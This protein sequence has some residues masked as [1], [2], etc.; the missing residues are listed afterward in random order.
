LAQLAFDPFTILAK[1]AKPAK[2]QK[3][4]GPK[5]SKGPR[6]K[7]AMDQ[8]PEEP[9]AKE[10][11]GSKRTRAKRANDLKGQ[12]AKRLGKRLN[13]PNWDKGAKDK[14]G[15][16]RQRVNGQKNQVLKGPRAKKYQ[17][18]KDQGSRVKMVKRAKGKQ[19]QKDL[20]QK[21]S[22]AQGQNE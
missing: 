20:D 3:G 18:R 6:P 9:N 8:G 21:G 13:G 1:R 2:V 17:G 4:R 5:R 12:W 22:G 14:G 11:Q 16:T 15:Q 10:D 19:D 7:I